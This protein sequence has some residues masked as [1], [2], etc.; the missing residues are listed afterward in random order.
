MDKRTSE[1]RFWSHVERTSTCWLWT[2]C[3][4]N[5][6]YGDT[7]AFGKSELAH[8]RSYVL[9]VGDIPP[10]LELDH[11]CR[12]QACVNP[13]HLEAVT[14]AENIRRGLAVKPKPS[15]CPR[16]HDYTEATAYVTTT[17]SRYCRICKNE[18]ARRARAE[19]A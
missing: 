2:G 18:R 17:G 6:G 8:R 7:K 3:R 5:Q 4:N 10:G 16:G 1:E 9:L 11:L 14:H 12:V 15:A 19:A 13:A